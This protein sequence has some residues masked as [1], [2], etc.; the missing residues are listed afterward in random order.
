MTGKLSAGS[1]VSFGEVEEGTLAGSS[2]IF[3]AMALCSSSLFSEAT[4]ER[5]VTTE[6][7]VLWDVWDEPAIL[8]SLAGFCDSVSEFWSSSHSSTSFRKD[9]TPGSAVD[10]L[11]DS[12]NGFLSS[13]EEDR[14]TT[15]ARSPALDD[16][17][18]LKAWVLELDRL[19]GL[20]IPPDELRWGEAFPVVTPRTGAICDCC[21]AESRAWSDGRPSPVSPDGGTDIAMYE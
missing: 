13:L 20:C 9:L 15:A 2:F 17:S 19:V 6:A 11:M 8:G 14:D 12:L 18:D 21:K 5:S 4:G 16:R 1:G 3:G 10:T 7:F